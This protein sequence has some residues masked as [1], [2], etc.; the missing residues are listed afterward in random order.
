MPS[1]QRQHARAPTAPRALLGAAAHAARLSRS[2]A[3]AARTV[4]VVSPHRASRQRCAAAITWASP[5]IQR[6]SMQYHW[7]KPP[8]HAAAVARI[9]FTV[10]K[11][12]ERR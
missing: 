12:R 5:R 11:A 2:A 3:P 4:P 1:F 10:R 6:R 8:Q 9:D 7:H